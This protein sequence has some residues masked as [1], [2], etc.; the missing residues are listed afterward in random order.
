[1]VD[2]GNIILRKTLK[3]RYLRTYCEG[4]DEFRECWEREITW[5]WWIPPPTS[6]KCVAARSV[7]GVEQNAKEEKVSNVPVGSPDYSRTNTSNLRWGIPPASNP[8]IRLEKGHQFNGMKRW[9]TSSDWC[10]YPR[11]RNR[12]EV[13]NRLVHSWSPSQPLL[14]T[15]GT[16]WEWCQQMM[17]RAMHGARTGLGMNKS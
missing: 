13:N 5:W 12:V 1:M 4:H 14:R 10:R 15:K 3:R 16:A 2:G 11:T 8:P 17:S 7:V 6:Q 9:I